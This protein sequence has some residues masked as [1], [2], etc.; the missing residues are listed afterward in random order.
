[1]TQRSSQSGFTLLE[2]LIASGISIM[3]IAIV[4]TLALDVTGFGTSLGGRLEQEMELEPVLR[5]MVTEIRSMGPADNGAYPVAQ[6][7]A[8]TL[9][10]YTDVDNDGKLERVRY[11]LDGTTLK[12]GVIA[13][14][15]TLPVTYPPANETV[16]EV[17]HYLV[18]GSTI[19]TYY[20]EGYPPSLTPM[21]AP[22]EI[23]K[24]RLI[25][26]TGTIDRDVNAEPGPTTLSISATIRNLRGDI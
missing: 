15:N 14:T 22:V 16:T 10:F 12:R 9:T 23:S 18:P 20:P 3:A 2:I 24:I 11:F 17:V 19:F 7:E 26:V 4:S 5:Q 21:P 1:M 25:T 13:P 6:A 8:Q